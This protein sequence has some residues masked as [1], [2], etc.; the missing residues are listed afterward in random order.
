MSKFWTF[1][2]EAISSYLTSN[3]RNDFNHEA[4][5]F[6]SAMYTGFPAL[7]VGSEK[8]QWVVIVCLSPNWEA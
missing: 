6:E 4:H 8:A 2:F 5:I 3:V 1:S 7:L